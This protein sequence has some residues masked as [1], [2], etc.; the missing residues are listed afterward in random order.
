MF[1]INN[2]ILLRRDLKVRIADILINDKDLTELNR[3]P[4][5]MTPKGS[6]STIRCCIY[7]ERAVTRSAALACFGVCFDEDDELKSIKEF[8]EERL[9]S[10]ELDQEVLTVLNEGCSACSKNSYFVT[11]ACR[12]CVARPC[13]MNCPAK[14][15]SFKGGHAEI[16]PD[17]CKNCGKCLEACPYHAITYIPVPC[18]EACPVDAIS[19][20]ENGIAKIDFTKCILCGKCMNACPFGAI[21]E[22]SHMPFVIDKLKGK[23]KVVAMIAPAIAGQFTVEYGKIVAGIIDLGFSEVAEVAYGAVETGKNETAEWL[24]FQD[25]RKPALTSSCCPAYVNLI[26]KHLP[27]KTEFV[28]STLSPMK[29]TSR[30]IKR[31]D[32]DA[33]TV[34]IG[35]CIAK[36]SEAFTDD[37]TDFVLSFEELGAMLV[38]KDVQL[39][40]L[41]NKDV[42]LTGDSAARNFA[43]TEG[44]SKA[45]ELN[46]PEGVDFKPEIINGI[47]KKSIFKIKAFMNGKLPTN[48]LEG[49]ACEGGCIAGPNSITNPKVGIVY[50]KKSL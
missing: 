32:P 47:D 7:K 38:A 6:E 27:E 37:N 36:K 31:R 14:A 10:P 48:F 21:F 46:I 19:K 44:V 35:P 9:E 43:V 20:D 39:M 28:S 18:Q 49:M 1:Q 29:Y 13:M 2:A 22:K 42:C 4:V 33:I 26:K 41:E 16:D 25:K 3:L 45:I 12:G 17:L 15:I 23:Q 24:E 5:M 34:F 30:E 8:A 11:N 40:E 50:H